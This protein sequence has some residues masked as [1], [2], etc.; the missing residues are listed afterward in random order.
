VAAAA[1]EVVVIVGVPAIAADQ[2]AAARADAAPTWLGRTPA[3]AD[4]AVRCY[5]L[6]S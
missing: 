4:R 5:R 1:A 3:G 2:R 6:P